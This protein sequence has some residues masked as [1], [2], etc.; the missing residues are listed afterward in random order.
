MC[1][2]LLR[3]HS[4]YRSRGFLSISIHRSVSSCCCC[5]KTAHFLG[6][7]VPAAGLQSQ[8]AST[9]TLIRRSILLFL[10]PTTRLILP[11]KILQ[12][13]SNKKD[14][15]DELSL[16]AYIG[17]RRLNSFSDTDHVLTVW[18]FSGLV[19][20]LSDDTTCPCPSSPAK[21]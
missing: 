2:K 6:M 21:E 17:Q 20:I 13:L 11:T 9:G 18:T 19:F 12:G 1:C 8:E 16:I 3:V 4:P 7:K 10:L 14:S 5:D 15:K